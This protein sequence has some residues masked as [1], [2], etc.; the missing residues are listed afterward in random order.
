MLNNVDTEPINRGHDDDS[1]QYGSFTYDNV[2]LTNCRV[3]RDP[4]IQLT[5]TSPKS[6]KEGHFRNLV[7]K[8]CTSPASMVDLGGGPRNNTLENGV[9]YYFHDY[10]GPGRTTKVASVHFPNTMQDGDYKS[11]AGFT[12]KDVRAADVTGIAF[13]TLL[14]PR[15]DLAPTTLITGV[16]Q[17]GSK[18]RVQGVS[19]DNDEIVTV[20]VNGLPASLLAQHSG[21]TDWEIVLRSPV[22]CLLAASATDRAG[23]HEKFVPVF[24]P[25]AG[26]FTARRNP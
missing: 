24:L 26:L 3:G 19:I 23:N 6:G 7:I 14:A 18:I 2:T 21:I 4:L 10:F 12:G 16:H 20:M 15:Y 22:N 5:C 9:V 1:I 25:S 17:E 8:N 13:P 11:I